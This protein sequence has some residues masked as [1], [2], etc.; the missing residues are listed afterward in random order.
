M[1]LEIVLGQFVTPADARVILL[2][3]VPSGVR[4]LFVIVVAVQIILLTGALREISSLRHR[5]SREFSQWFLHLLQFPLLCIIS[6][7]LAVVLP[8]EV[9][10]EIMVVEADVAVAVEVIGAAVRMQW[11]QGSLIWR[12]CSFLSLLVTEFFLIPVLL[13]HSLH[14]V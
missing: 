11:L 2:D 10:D 8:T 13:I 7:V 6:Q 12:V 5:C 9:E 14:L 1:P 4:Q 3:F